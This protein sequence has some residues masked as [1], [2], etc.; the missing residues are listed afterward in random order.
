MGESVDE[1]GRA[2]TRGLFASGE[3]T[4]VR[5]RAAVTLGGEVGPQGEGV[6]AVLVREIL[7]ASAPSGGDCDAP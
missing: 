5:W 3:N 7:E 4:F 1:L 6:P 2:R